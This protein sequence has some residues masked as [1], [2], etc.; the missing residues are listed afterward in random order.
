MQP[1]RK[2]S[3]LTQPGARNFRRDD[4]R[5]AV[6]S[7]FASMSPYSA[8]RILGLTLAKDAKPRSRVVSVLCPWHSE[9]G[10]SCDLTV[11]GGKLLAVCR[12]CKRGGGVIDI[13]GAIEGIN[14]KGADYFRVL[15]RA[16]EIVGVD[17]RPRGRFEPRP[18]TELDVVRAQLRDAHREKE[19][20]DGA[21]TA[22]RLSHALVVAE[23]LA[24]IDMLEG[25]VDWLS[26]W[27]IAV[28]RRIGT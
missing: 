28:E 20:A 22:E 10:P 18:V 15:D 17:V 26:R 7:A 16:A 1:M 8:A 25:V 3:P 2:D 6:L 24:R 12:S 5:D 4:D 9:R 19:A 21:A 23:L 14:P 27:L 11:K 13:V